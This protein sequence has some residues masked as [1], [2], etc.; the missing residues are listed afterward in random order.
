[1]FKSRNS[2]PNGSITGDDL[3]AES[4]LT[5]R[6]RCGIGSSFTLRIEDENKTIFYHTYN[7]EFSVQP[8]G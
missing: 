2:G 8:E 4:G 7:R 3:A 1:M 5:V 6:N